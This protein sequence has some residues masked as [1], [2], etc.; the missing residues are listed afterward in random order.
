MLYSTAN[1]ARTGQPPEDAVHCCLFHSAVYICNT[2]RM[3]KTGIYW[4]HVDDK[5]IVSACGRQ[6]YIGRMWRTGI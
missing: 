6:V 2:G 5:Y 1:S 3:W 4:A